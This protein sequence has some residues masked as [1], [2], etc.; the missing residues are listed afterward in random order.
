MS[1]CDSE[2]KAA[3]GCRQDAF[4]CDYCDRM[5][6]TSCGHVFYY[7]RKLDNGGFAPISCESCLYGDNESMQD[8]TECVDNTEHIDDTEHIDTGC[9]APGV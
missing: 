8:D 7:K 3:I 1:C 5:Y 4:I 2:W 9:N 6:Y